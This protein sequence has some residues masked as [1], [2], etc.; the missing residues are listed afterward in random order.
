M[1]QICAPLGS[2]E[3]G[4]GQKEVHLLWLRR[5][6]RR[7]G[8]LEQTEPSGGYSRLRRDSGEKT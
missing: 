4:R 1:A 6:G 8:G 7:A 5:E 3:V 2:Q